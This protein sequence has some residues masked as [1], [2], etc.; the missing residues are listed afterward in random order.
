V[1]QV[2]FPRL[3]QP[4]VLA[5]R[6][7]RNRVVHPSMSTQMAANGAVTPEL[8][9][10]FANRA[11]GGAAM[12]VSE[13]LSFAR[14]QA[15]KNRV[16][17]FDDSDVEGLSRWA[18]AVESEDCR[19]IA[20]ILDRGRGR[21]VPGRIY[22]AISASVLP[23]DLSLSVPRAMS[24][25]EIRRFVEEIALSCARVKKCGF[26]GVELSAGHGHLFHQFLS[27]RMNCRD[28]AYGGSTENRARLVV[29]LLSAIRNECGSAFIVGVKLPGDD[30]QPGSIGPD[31]AFRLA[32]HVV[33]SVALDFISFAQ[34]CH[35]STLDMHV[36]DSF[37]PRLTYMPL[38]GRLRGAVE[39]VPV[40]ALGR[41]SD[42]AEAEGILERGEADLVGVGR[43][44]ITDAAWFLKAKA[45]RTH[46]MRYCVSCNTCWQRITADAAPLRCDNNPKLAEPDE[47][48]YWPVPVGTDARKRVVVVGA[49]IAGLEASWVA[50]ARGHQVTLFG[51]SRDAGGKTRTRAAL[52]GG[53]ERASIYDYQ[54]AAAA[55]AGVQLQLGV[56]ATAEDVRALAPDHVVLATGS[57]MIAP[58]WLG[59]ELAESGLVP[60]LRASILT[61]MRPSSPSGGTAVVYDTDM[62]EGTYAAVELLKDRFARV[63]L[64]TPREAIA[65]YSTLVTRQGI[66][67]R[68]FRKR[69]EIRTFTELRVSESGLEQGQV[70]CI[71]VYSG[72]REVIENVEFVSWSTPRAPTIVLRDEL[73]ALGLRVT[74]VGDCVSARSTLE[75]VAEGHAAGAA[76]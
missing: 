58:D 56:T 36:P 3:S 9:R 39:G 37:Q 8:V 7:L 43:A 70:E 44:M 64:V 31:E 45:G 65:Q 6:T 67:R 24:L 10:Y 51:S 28:D 30:G 73:S 75:A 61:V 26:S 46:A 42:P 12:V 66:L 54:L 76:I 1:E 62:G 22:N 15:A 33:R 34:G 19:L 71:H 29:E 40:I 55:K 52:P 27:P 11:K 59:A 72:D 23:D 53:E 5:G 48:D 41:I 21:N 17:A 20:Q 32:Q 18:D 69:I 47:V 14:H 60:D 13:P 74:S 25:D 16:A 63:V 35:A 2:S 38:L 50:A 68:L 49:G 57:E 4:I